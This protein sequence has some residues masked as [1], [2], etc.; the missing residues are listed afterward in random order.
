MKFEARFPC[1]FIIRF[2]NGFW[3]YLVGSLTVPGENMSC[4]I[5]GSKCV[6]QKQEVS[7][8]E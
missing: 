7:K 8:N 3:D 5:H 6:K 2:K 1:G 4:P